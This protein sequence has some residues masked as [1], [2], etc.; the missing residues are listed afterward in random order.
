LGPT[1]KNCRFFPIKSKKEKRREEKRGKGRRGEGQREG[2]YSEVVSEDGGIDP[3]IRRVWKV[4]MC[5]KKG[6]KTREKKVMRQKR[7][8]E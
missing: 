4:F 3:Y 5:V 6:I 1:P 8:L 7:R 2:K